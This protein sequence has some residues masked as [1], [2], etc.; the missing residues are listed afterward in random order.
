MQKLEG[1]SP[2]REKG[3]SLLERGAD[4]EKLEGSEA[5]LVP[6]TSSSKPEQSNGTQSREP[7]ITKTG[8]YASPEA[9]LQEVSNEFKYWSGRL[10][11]TSLQMCYALIAANWLVFGSLSGILGSVWAKISLL[12]VLLALATNVV[13]AWILTEDMRRRIDYGEEQYDRW[14]DEFRAASGKKDPWP[15]TQRMVDVGIQTRRIKAGLTLAGGVFWIIGAI[16]KT[17]F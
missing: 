13:G 5:A 15:F 14:S 1:R 3:Y 2:E 16:G 4:L 6:D 12:T 11:E 7:S 17:I 10:T 8:L 9:A